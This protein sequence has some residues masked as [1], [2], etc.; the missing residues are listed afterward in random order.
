MKDKLQR[1]VRDNREAFDV[2][3][4]SDDLW[5]RLSEKLPKAEGITSPEAP[6]IPEITSNTPSK[7]ATLNQIV[8]EDFQNGGSYN[9]FF[10]KTGKNLNWRIAASIALLLGLGWAGYRINQNYGVTEAPEVALA[11][12]GYAKQM[13]QYTQLI[14]NKRTELRQMTESDP[15][16][17][18]EFAVEL[19]QLERSYQ[20]LKADLPKN[21]NRETVIQAMIQ[22]LQWQID[23]LNQQLDILQ[24][25]KNKNNHANDKLI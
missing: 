11:N 1:F 5:S 10:R 12:P 14:D 24:R 25:I 19:D 4:P 8:H 2:H 22:N 23:L 20:N 6:V 3:E 21:P 16:L 15:A 17:Y 9:P 13:T 7:E 18:K